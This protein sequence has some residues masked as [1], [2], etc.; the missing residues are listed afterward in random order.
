MNSIMIIKNNSVHIWTA[1][2]SLMFY[3][4]NISQEKYKIKRF[5]A[6]DSSIK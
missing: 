1:F 5:A 2:H 6:N 3:N 4:A